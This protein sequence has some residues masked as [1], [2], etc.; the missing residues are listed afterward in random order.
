MDELSVKAVSA[1]RASWHSM[2]YMLDKLVGTY[3]PNLDAE[4]IAQ[5]DWEYICGAIMCIVIL[6][7][8]FKAIR[9]VLRGIT[10]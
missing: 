8:F 4:G 5:I 9:F 2:K 7:T 6:I 10:S 3:T 1:T